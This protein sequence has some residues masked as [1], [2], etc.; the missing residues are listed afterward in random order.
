MAKDSTSGLDAAANAVCSGVR[1]ICA[2]NCESLGNDSIFEGLV[3][4]LSWAYHRNSH[5][6]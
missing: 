2:A 6:K 4:F 3:L 1:P 5:T